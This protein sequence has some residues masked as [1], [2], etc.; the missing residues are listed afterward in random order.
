[1]T[2]KG[3]DLGEM[4]HSVFIYCD[5]LHSLFTQIPNGDVCIKPEAQGR[6][7]HNETKHEV[8]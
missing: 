6:G 5:I 8:L 3:D 1:M 4:T 7:R 2:R